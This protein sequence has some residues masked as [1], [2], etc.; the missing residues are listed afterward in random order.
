MFSTDMKRNVSCWKCIFAVLVFSVVFIGCAKTEIRETKYNN[1]QTKERYTVV[2]D[3]EGNYLWDGNYSCWYENGQVKCTGS[4][5]RRKPA[6]TTV[7]AT[8]IHIGGRV[9][10][11]DLWYENGQKSQDCAYKD[12]KL[13]GPFAAWYKN[14]QKSQE[15]IYKDGKLD[16]PFATW[17][18]NGHKKVERVFKD[19]KAVERVFKDGKAEEQKYDTVKDADG[20]VYT[21]VKIGNQIWTVENLRTTKFDDGSEIPL[22]T[23]SAAWRSLTTPGYCWYD[24]DTNNKGKYGALY[25]WYTVDTKKLAPAGWHVPSDSEWTV[26]ENYLIANGYNW[27]GTT[28]GNKIA[29]SM[30]AR[31]YWIASTSTGAIGNDFTANNRSGF[32]A[33]PGGCREDYEGHFRYIGQVGHWW[34]ASV[35]RA[36]N[37]YTRSLDDVNDFLFK[38]D[39]STKSHGLSVRLVRD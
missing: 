35:W 39:M 3:K 24:N 21:T 32:S 1:G 31:T 18:E 16:G 27:D 20:N 28:T 9:G 36:L 17:Y 30:A 19:G 7:D 38:Y 29:K 25:N 10:K 4:Y 2:K 13:D 26:L 34:S 5:S 37:T 15:C 22:V 23:D 33:L 12:G 8:G 14:G 6:D 11:W